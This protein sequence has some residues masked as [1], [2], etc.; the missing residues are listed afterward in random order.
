MTKR[1][2][3]KK[4]ANLKFKSR[5]RLDNI[6]K[7][8]KT[9]RLGLLNFYKSQLK[10][11]PEYLDRG[12]KRKFN[13]EIHEVDKDEYIGKKTLKLQDERS[14]LPGRLLTKKL[15]CESCNKIF[16]TSEAFLSHK[17]FDKKHK[18]PIS[19]AAFN[20]RKDEFELICPIANCCFHTNSLDIYLQHLT[21]HGIHEK[22]TVYIYQ[23]P[24]PPKNILECDRCHVIFT[25]KSS[26]NKH[27]EQCLGT[28]PIICAICNEGFDDTLSLLDHI[29][30]VHR[31]NNQYRL[32]H[33]F[34]EAKR[35]ADDEDDEY[36]TKQAQNFASMRNKIRKKRS[37][38]LIYTI[39]FNKVN[40]VPE[41]L[42]DNLLQ[43]TI[44]QLHFEASKNFKIKFSFYLHTVISK[45]DENGK[46]KFQNCG[47][48]SSADFLIDYGTNIEKIALTSFEDLLS[49]S[50]QVS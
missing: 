36:G 27:R 40:D 22:N 25:R 17:K 41:I 29:D 1:K 19:V 38:F 9:E 44:S 21:F 5:T 37:T 46:K 42:D 4:L 34:T 6:T 7:K 20:A 3:E 15:K 33:E 31:P 30:D 48:I 24:E 14:R 16:V 32:L 11:K 43:A 13:P 39:L 12:A 50:E 26:L 2:M 23:N 10:N 45:Y 47:L 28:Q 18:K 35:S 49:R 8:R